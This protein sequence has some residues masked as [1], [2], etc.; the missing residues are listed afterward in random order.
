MQKVYKEK[1]D[2]DSANF[3]LYI[4]S[5]NLVMF[6]NMSAE[7]HWHEDLEF[8]Y[9]TKGFM[10]YN[11]NGEVITLHEGEGV[12]VNSRQLHFGFTAD[13]S[14]CEYYCIL[15]NPLLLESVPYL[16]ET[17]IQTMLSNDSYAFS[18]LDPAIPVQGKCLQLLQEIYNVYQE[19]A[20][21][22]EMVIEGCFFQLWGYLFLNM[23]EPE[24]ISSIYRH[25]LNMMKEMMS[26]IQSNYRD[27][28]TLADI[29][30]AGN[31]AP[32]TCS[33]DFKKYLQRTPMEYVK[34]VRLSNAKILLTET[35]LTITEIAHQCGF[36]GSSYFTET[37][38]GQLGCTPREYRK[39]TQ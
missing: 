14:D 15:M 38:R 10:K 21:G 9:I 5:G 37:F 32:S 3:P 16:N 6:P 22:F 19:K 11:V 25:N 34:E 18:H 23:P 20:S 12:F 29:A 33:A 13:G 28:M 31:V 1:V 30:K 39:A 24:E 36:S 8:M 4:K 27:K 7:C 2:Y 35:D 26:Y 17:Y